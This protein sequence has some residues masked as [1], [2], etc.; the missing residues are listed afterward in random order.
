MNAGRI[1]DVAVGVLIRDASESGP[2]AT[3]PRA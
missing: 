2:A 3:R 1:V